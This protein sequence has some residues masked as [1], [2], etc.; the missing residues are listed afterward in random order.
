[1]NSFFYFV[2]SSNLYFLMFLSVL[3]L[4][5]WSVV[6]LFATFNWKRIGNIILGA[7]F[8]VILSY[9]TLISRGHVFDMQLTPFYSFIAAKSQPEIYRSVFMN[10]LLFVPLGAT[11]PYALSRLPKKRNIFVTIV[12]AFLLSA[13]IEFLQYY[14]H[15]GRCE[16]DDVIFN[17]LGAAFGTLSYCLYLY[18][19][20]RNQE[21][22][23]LMQNTISDIQK[24]LLDLCS[25]VIFDKKVVLSRDINIDS[26]IDESRV[27]TVLPTA[28]TAL[29][30]LSLECKD[31][32]S[33]FS[34][35]IAKNMR[36]EYAHCE[37]HKLLSENN[38]KY[39]ILKGCASATYYKE[40][41]LRMMGDIDFLVSPNDIKKADELLRSI[42]YTTNYDINSNGMH[43]EYRR[44]DGLVCEMHRLVNGIPRNEMS[45]VVKGYLKDVFDTA[46]EINTSSGSLIVPDKFHHGLVILLHSA[47]HIINEGIGLRHLCDW[48]VFVNSF[49][50]NEFVATFQKPLKEMGLFRF[51]QLITLCCI[52]YL[53]VDKQEW[54]GEFDN[55]LLDDIITDILNGGNFGRNDITR[56]NQIKYISNRK[57]GTVGE[58][59]AVFQVLHTLNEKAKR[60][61]NF[62]KKTPFLLPLGWISVVFKYAGLVIRGKRSLDNINTIRSADTRKTLYK[63]FNLFQNEKISK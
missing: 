48:A 42:G 45:S 34:Q 4:I 5:F 19:L 2:Y 26:I 56:Y 32:D 49:S 53:G 11:L 30:K 61:I 39:V 36:V 17:T 12:I 38:I 7:I 3:I 25:N 24:T 31:A 46:I 21:K 62:V 15:L 28:Y 55:D 14:Y 23:S 37:I 57:K 35:I 52:K 1:M 27:Q 33:L 50:N 22:G 16:T 47:S 41:L 6:N 54:V 9:L 60:E 8:I 20:K 18:L 44:K 58:R 59:N 63:K 51:A 40:P 43:I 10:F 29:K 13:V